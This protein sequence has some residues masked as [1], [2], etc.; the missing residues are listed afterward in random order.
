VKDATYTP[1]LCPVVDG[2][3]VPWP[4]E[5]EPADGPLCDSCHEGIGDKPVC[6]GCYV[7]E[8]NDADERYEALQREHSDMS[9][10]YT[11]ERRAHE[12]TVRQLHERIT[13]DLQEQA[14]AGQAELG[15][16]PI[17]HADILRR[18]RKLPGDYAPW[19]DVDRDAPEHNHLPYVDCSAGCDHFLPLHEALGLDDWGVCVNPDSHR[20]GLLTFE[21]Q[22]C[23][24]AEIVSD[25]DDEDNP[26][27]Q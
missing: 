24:E 5:K 27:E 13:A 21:H 15:I 9:A 6:D 7:Q 4:G 11:A 10:L 19:G 16:S 18:F 26:K 25:E 17:V 20:C 12:E 2:A 22:G 1:W 3:E 14:E 8:L 23:H